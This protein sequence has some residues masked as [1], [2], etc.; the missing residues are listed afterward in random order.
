MQSIKRRYDRFFI[1]F[2]REL[3]GYSIDG[4]EPNGYC[5]IEI[6]D[7][8]GKVSTYIQ[9]LKPLKDGSMYRV[10]LIAVQGDKSLGVPIGW[11]DIDDRGRGECRFEFNPDNLDGTGLAIE[12]FNVGAIIIKGDNIKELIAPIV[13]YKDKEILWKNGF[14]D[15]SSFNHKAEP[16]ESNLTKPK[17]AEA[18]TK[19]VSEKECQIYKKVPNLEQKSKIDNTFEPMSTINSLG[20]FL[21]EI[22][23]SSQS[24]KQ[25]E[26]II[27]PKIEAA[28]KIINSINE[29]P[30][31]PKV[32]HKIDIE[33]ASP[34]IDNIHKSPITNLKEETELTK[35][36]E[37]TNPHKIFNDMVTK[38]YAE[39]EEL[40]KYKLLTKEDAKVLDL[41]F[42]SP[43]VEDLDDLSYMFKNNESI[44]PFERPN[45]EIVWIKIA[46]FELVTLNIPSWT[47]IKHQ[48]INA[49]WKKYKHLILGRYIKNN[50]Y[51]Y[52]LGIPDTYDRNYKFIANNLG[53][54]KFIPC[55]GRVEQEGEQGYWIME[56]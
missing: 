17:K 39:M 3:N 10:Y 25:D 21:A 51:N 45:K 44:V 48:F 49:A 18:T 20:E 2:K 41:E 53:F 12:D 1:M 5:K 4:R 16:K 35:S 22:D 54:R 36:D 50:C 7:G 29:S 46:P 31:P 11:L 26:L 42:K 27:E 52:I 14:K 28:P 37:E 23:Y 40:E 13:G 24:D 6:R 47:Y 43:V 19:A 9:G 38:F 33:A 15:F 34:K 32:E 55:K 56:L 8:K 30:I